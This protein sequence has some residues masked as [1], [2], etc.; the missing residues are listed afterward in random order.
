MSK[1]T[2]KI[3]HNFNIGDVVYVLNEYTIV[4]SII[5]GISCNTIYSKE[6]NPFNIID[7][8]TICYKVKKL[9]KYEDKES[10]IIFEVSS[11]QYD[12]YDYHSSKVYANVDDLL[13]D[14]RNSVEKSS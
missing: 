11:S 9:L 2:K 4:Q 5:V 10:K 8:T 7:K 3:N 12:V 1:I 14:L 13:S 6:Y